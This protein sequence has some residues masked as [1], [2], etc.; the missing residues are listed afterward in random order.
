M[1]MIL[2]QG[3]E[4]LGGK[5]VSLPSTPPHYRTDVG[6]GSGP[7]SSMNERFRGGVAEHFISDGGMVGAAS[8]MVVLRA[9]EEEE[10]VSRGGG[11]P[12]QSIGSLWGRRWQEGGGLGTALRGGGPGG[13]SVTS[14]MCSPSGEASKRIAHDTMKL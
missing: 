13:S 4:S 5:Q 2:L 12:R 1:V 3:I 14:P 8:R 10:E 9:A 7:S 11:G 6:S